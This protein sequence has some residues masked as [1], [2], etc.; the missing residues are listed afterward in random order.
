MADEANFVA[1]FVQLLMHWLC[2]MRSSIVEKNWALSVDLMA[3]AG[4][5]VFG[6]SH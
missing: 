5:V 2:D 4:F 6:A 3:A 1:Q